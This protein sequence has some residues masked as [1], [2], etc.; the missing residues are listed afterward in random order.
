MLVVF[1]CCYYYDGY[2]VVYRRFGKAVEYEHGRVLFCFARCPSKSPGVGCRVSGRGPY[3]L[4]V[5]R[6]RRRRRLSDCGFCSSSE[7]AVPCQENS[8]LVFIGVW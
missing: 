8:G 7:V 1:W 2:F 6:R 5:A 4:G 3:P